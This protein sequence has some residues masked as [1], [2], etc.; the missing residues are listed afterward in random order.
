MDNLSSQKTIPNLPEL[1][2][3]SKKIKD[4]EHIEKAFKDEY[5]KSLNAEQDTPEKFKELCKEIIKKA[6]PKTGTDTEDPV[7][8]PKESV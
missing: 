6:W 7:F 3:F 1:P 8:L 4:W 5:E 2:S